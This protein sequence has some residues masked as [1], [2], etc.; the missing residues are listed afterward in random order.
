MWAQAI[1]QFRAGW[2]DLDVELFDLKFGMARLSAIPFSD[3]DSA[4]TRSIPESS[5][6]PCR[7][8]DGD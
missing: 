2:R 3:H 6:G 8:T 5:S 1:N 7:H 4:E